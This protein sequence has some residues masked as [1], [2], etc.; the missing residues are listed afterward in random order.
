M[1]P[2]YL[3]ADP[4]RKL[5]NKTLDYFMQSKAEPWVKTLFVYLYYY[6]VRISEALAVVVE[7][8]VV[9]ED[10]ELKYLSVT[11]LTLKN[12]T[13]D[14]RVLWVPMTQPYIQELLGYIKYKDTGK[15]WSYSRQW[16]RVKLQQTLP[17]ITPHGFR[18]NRLDDFAQKGEN[19]YA[20]K[21]WAGWSDIRPGDSY[22]QAV[23]TRKMAER[24]FKTNTK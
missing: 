20:L 24:Y 3:H 23:D 1:T 5:T 21:S 11:S 7:D 19:P 16:A 10:D 22:V 17:W 14:S 18:H 4:K 6:G 2:N 12:P 9:S 8:F 13:Q 15:L